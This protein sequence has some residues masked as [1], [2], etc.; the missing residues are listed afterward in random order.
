MGAVL[1]VD[2]GGTKLAAAVVDA[3]GGIHCRATTATPVTD[4]PHV[5]AVALCRLIDQVVAAGPVQTI[6][7]AGIACAGPMDG[8]TVSPVNIPAWRQYDVVGTVSQALPGRPVVLANDG[9]CMAL[10]EYWR[11]GHPSSGADRGALLGIVV[12]TGVGGG[13]VL[14]GK[15]YCG[16]SG[17]AGHI[18]HTVI[19]IDGEPCPCGGK[20]CVEAYA[21]GPSMAS[22][23]AANGWDGESL[24]ARRLAHDA[25]AGHPVAVAAFQR[26]ADAL[27]AA[28]VSAAALF[29]LDDVVVGGG[30]AAAGDVLFSPLRAGIRARSGLGF[31]QRLRIHRSPLG[32]DAGLLGAAALALDA[33]AT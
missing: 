1:A 25:R 26:G 2:I 10:G 14:D 28:I 19:E 15:V 23:A 24:D 17:N 4:D 29:D 27:A 33:V 30:V 32:A 9:T 13:V 6:V 20:G 12:S 16:G 8:G 18:G 3:E 22:W 5:V 31:L 11:G 7:A 21:S